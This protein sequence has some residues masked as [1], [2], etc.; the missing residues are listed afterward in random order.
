MARPGRHFVIVAAP[1]AS[2]SVLPDRTRP[3]STSTHAD[4]EADRPGAPHSP[5][6]KQYSRGSLQRGAAAVITTLMLLFAMLL[7]AAYANR[8]LLSEQRSSVNQY[9]STQAFEAAEAGIEWATAHLN[10]DRRIGL[11]CLPTADST[12]LSFRARYLS[13][14]PTAATFTPVPARQ[15]GAPAALHPACVRS[16]SGWSCGCPQAGRPALPPPAAG[17]AHGGAFQLEFLPTGRPGTVRVV[18][19][20]CNRPAGACWPGSIAQADASLRIEAA[21]GLLP[22]LRTAPAAS[23]TTR[24]AFDADTAALGVHNSDPTTGVGIHAGSHI[25]AGH[26][27]LTGAAGA[28]LGGLLLGQDA[29]L[30]ALSTDQFFATYFG[31]GKQVWKTQPAVR[32][33]V[34]EGD[35]G[36]ALQAAIDDAADIAMIWVDGDLALAGPLALGTADRPVVIVVE[37]TSRL[38]GA[39]ALHGL[40]YSGAMTWRNTGFGASEGAYVR[41]AVLSE[42]DYRGDGTPEFFYAAGVLARLKSGGGSFARVNGSWRDF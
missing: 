28:P 34:C 16:G 19:T 41:G 5:P 37:G 38:D 33:V 6:P 25:A 27:R 20:G 9:R 23:V 22:S 26:A 32:R 42:G 29:A 30:A 39:V 3:L 21:L 18:A 8:S 36:R 24:G 14:D 17:D 4:V 11:D 1:G 40:I 7:T 31:I 15:S 12:A 13:F 35:C 2:S 10:N